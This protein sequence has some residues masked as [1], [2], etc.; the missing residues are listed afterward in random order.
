VG[1]DYIIK[2]SDQSSVIIIIFYELNL[3][4]AGQGGKIGERMVDS[5]WMGNKIINYKIMLNPLAKK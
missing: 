5:G 3:F 4:H 2:E 1:L